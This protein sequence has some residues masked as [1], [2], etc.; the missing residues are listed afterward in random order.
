MTDPTAT[1]RARPK[2][3]PKNVHKFCD[4]YPHDGQ[5]VWVRDRTS[6]DWHPGVYRAGCRRVT[7]GPAANPSHVPARLLD[8]WRPA[9]GPWADLVPLA[10]G[11]PR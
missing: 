1:P 9:A 6:K 3:R 5:S 4:H 2:G 10:P 11:A 7:V 8:A